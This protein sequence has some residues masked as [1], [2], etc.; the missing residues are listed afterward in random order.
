MLLL[1]ITVRVISAISWSFPVH[2]ITELS[3]LLNLLLSQLIYNYNIFSFVFKVPCKLAYVYGVCVYNPQAQKKSWIPD[4]TT[5]KHCLCKK[6]S[7]G[8]YINFITW[9]FPVSKIQLRF[10]Y[11]QNELVHSGRV[12]PCIYEDEYCESTGNLPASVIWLKTDHSFVFFSHQFETKMTKNI[13]RFRLESLPVKKEKIARLSDP[14]YN[15]NHGYQNTYFE[16]LSSIEYFY[17]NQLPYHKTQYEYIL[18]RY[19]GDCDTNTGLLNNPK[20]YD[21]PISWQQNE[22]YKS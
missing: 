5:N 10:D 19:D 11:K 7:D 18:L 16:V 12:L 13:N 22:V 20:S 9:K 17:N 2:D 15:Q 4:A 21:N 8:R 6:Q 1:K 3:N 14:P